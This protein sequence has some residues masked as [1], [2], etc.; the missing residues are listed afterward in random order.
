MEHS[1]LQEKPQRNRTTCGRWSQ[2]ALEV[3]NSCSS[4]NKELPYFLKLYMY[5]TLTL[6]VQ[7]VFLFNITV[8]ISYITSTCTLDL[9]QFAANILPGKNNFHMFGKN[10]KDFF[11]FLPK[12][13]I[14]NRV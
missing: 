2:Q 8:N 9:P 6:Y 4:S 1:H 3:I 13:L 5:T 7:L 11:L 14:L 12:H 10:Q